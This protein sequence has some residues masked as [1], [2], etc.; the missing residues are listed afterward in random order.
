MAL[1]KENLAQLIA[2]QKQDGGLDKL[3]KEM[4]TIPAEIEGL[5]AG[6]EKDK[7]AVASAKSQTM[8][9]E[10]LKKT[11][12]LD[13]AAKEEAAK[14]HGGELN[15]VKTNEAFK[16][17]QHEIERAKADASDIETQILEIMDQLDASRKAEKA[18]AAVLKVSEDEVKAEVSHRESQLA[19]VKARFEAAKVLRDQKAAPV[20]AEAMKVYN[21]VRSRGKLD[22]VV[23][24]DATTCSACRVILAPQVIV[25]ATKA[26]ALVTCESCQRI[27]YKAETTVPAQA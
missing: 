11:K 3:Q 20:P 24:I 10:K 15:Q 1:T 21:H 26:K 25:E 9:L 17:L 16:A 14:K 19:E 13:V 8:T 23:P 7:A 18:A 6:L 12:E 27:L 5:R 2:L 4:D 22:A